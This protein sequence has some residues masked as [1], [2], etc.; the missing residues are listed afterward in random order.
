MAV[1]LKP[2]VVGPSVIEEKSQSRLRWVAL[3]AL[4]LATLTWG[5]VQCFTQNA[6]VYYFFA[7]FMGS[8]AAMW[9]VFDARLREKPLVSIVQFLVFISWPIAVPIYLISTRGFRGFGWSV[10]NFVCLV[11]TLCVGFYSTLLVVYG[12]DSIWPKP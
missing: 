6:G 12:P 3:V 9:V 1:T 10:L 7:L 8:M 4:Y 2:S 5:V 11:L